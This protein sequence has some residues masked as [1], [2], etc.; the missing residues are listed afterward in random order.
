MNIF[1]PV[2]LFFN[3]SFG[4]SS[5]ITSYNLLWTVWGTLNCPLIVGHSVSLKATLIL[6]PCQISCLKLVWATLIVIR[7]YW[8]CKYY[9]VCHFCPWKDTQLVQVGWKSPGWVRGRSRFLGS[10]DFH[11]DFNVEHINYSHINV[12]PTLRGQ[13]SVARFDSG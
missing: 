12:P 11:P 2:L 10:H 8:W 7:E 4:S 1:W 6:N 3:P 9:T 13:F 5:S